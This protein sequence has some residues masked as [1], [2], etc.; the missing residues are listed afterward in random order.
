V[1]SNF[2]RCGFEDGWS[3]RNP[4]FRLGIVA[5]Q[6]GSLGRVRVTFNEFDRMLSYWLPIV[7]SK[8]QNDKVYWLRDVGEQVVCLMDERDEAGVVLGAIYAQADA[9]PVQSA[10][11]FHLGFKDGTAIEYDRGAHVLALKFEDSTVIGYN[12]GQH[13]LGLNFRDSTIIEYDGGQHALTLSFEDQTAIKYDA[14]AHSLGVAFSD[15][16][17][18][19][20][21]GVAHAFA[22][23]GS[24]GTSAMVSA[25]AGIMLKSDPSYVNILPS[26]VTIYPPLP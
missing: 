14:A 8:T 20:Y 3:V 18:I 26:G 17:T 23:L 2:C 24:I 21:D 13:V 7:V 9:T 5:D 16:T 6:D 11:K 1:S 15:G 19:T 22:M 12:S 4:A 25:P 10:D